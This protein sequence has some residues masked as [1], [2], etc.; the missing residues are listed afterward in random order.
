MKQSDLATRLGPV[1]A[2]LP[3]DRRAAIEAAMAIG[4]VGRVIDAL[5]DAARDL[6]TAARDVA[7][8]ADA[9]FAEWVA[10]GRSSRRP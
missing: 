3:A 1:L 2:R 9:V 4:N 10:E 5:D 7:A 6:R 8:G